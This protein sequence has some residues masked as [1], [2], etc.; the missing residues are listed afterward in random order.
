[1]HHKDIFKSSLLSEDALKLQRQ[2]LKKGALPQ[3][4]QVGWFLLGQ[5]SALC[6]VK[7]ISLMMSQ[8]GFEEKTC[9]EQE[10]H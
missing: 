4:N 7:K 5:L 6:F 10:M 9:T 2:W 1:M 3:F 8:C